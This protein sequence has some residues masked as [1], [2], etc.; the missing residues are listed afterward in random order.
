MTRIDGTA[1][2]A[3]DFRELMTGFPTGVTVLTTLDAEGVPMGLTCTSLCAVSLEPP[4]LLVCIDNRSRTL[5]AVQAQG[6]FAVNM[7]HR[8]GRAAA[9]VFAAGAHDR[10]SSIE[11]SATG[12][13]GLPRLTGHAHTVAECRV[14]SSTPAGDHT[15]VIGGVVAVEHLAAR[16]PLL[17]GLREYAAWP[18][19]GPG[20]PGETGGSGGNAADPMVNRVEAL[21]PAVTPPMTSS[22]RTVP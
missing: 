5:R 19:G 3:G 2:G 14:H 15:V 17:Y 18:G 10:F 11:W 21:D 16:A 1:V 7:L 8:H 20:G 6:F 4:M 9:E 13:R 22:G 12:D